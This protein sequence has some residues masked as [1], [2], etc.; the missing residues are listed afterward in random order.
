MDVFTKMRDL[1]PDGNHALGNRVRAC[2][3]GKSNGLAAWEGLHKKMAEGP[4][5]VVLPAAATAATNVG[6]PAK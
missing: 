3:S 6:L 5:S 2:G 1:P 4:V